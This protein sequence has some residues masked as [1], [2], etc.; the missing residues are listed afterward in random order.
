MKFGVSLWLWTAPVTNDV[1][2]SYAPKIAELGF[3]TV[4]IPL[5]IPGASRL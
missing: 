3:D 1:I 5:K 4:E 2:A